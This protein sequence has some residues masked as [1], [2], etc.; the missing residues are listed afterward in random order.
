MSP[1]LI[2]EGALFPKRWQGMSF[3]LPLALQ[4]LANAWAVF[5]SASMAAQRMLLRSVR[6]PLFALKKVQVAYDS[7]MLA[8]MLASQFGSSS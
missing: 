3:S 2:H 6:V 8:A 4:Y 5:G 7:M 1:R